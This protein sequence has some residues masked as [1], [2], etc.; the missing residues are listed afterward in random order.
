MTNGFKTKFK[1]SL[2]RELIRQNGGKITYF[3][4][5]GIV[6]IFIGVVYIVVSIL[7]NKAHFLSA[8]KIAVTFFVIM[9]GVAFAFP[10]LLKG[11]TK[12]LSTMRIIVFMFANVICMLLLNIGWNESSLENIGLN[13]YWMGVIAFLFGAKTAQKYF[14]NFRPNPDKTGETV[15]SSKVESELS[16]IAIAQIA[17]VQNE[18]RLLAQFPNIESISETVSLGESCLTLYLNDEKKAG[19]PLSVD[20]KLN[21]NKIVKV[22]TEI[23]TNVGK[24]TI[25]YGQLNHNISDSYSKTYLGSICCAVRSLNYPNFRGIITSGH[26]FT[27]GEYEDYGGYIKTDQIREAYSNDHVIGKLFYQ[28]MNS[29]QD[30]AIVELIDEAVITNEFMTF[31][32]DFYECSIEDL[33]STQPNVTILSKDNKE[34]KAFILDYNYTRQI[35]YRATPK[36]VTNLVVIGSAPKKQDSKSLTKGG[37]SGSCVFHN[38]TKRLIGMLVGGDDKFSFVLP[39][40]ETLRANNLKIL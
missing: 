30:L 16:Q 24:A 9:L 4:I 19:I 28:E 15:P 29:S 17:K 21:D 5:T 37:D 12:E 27:H 31:P 18:A 40:D 22:K 25:Q 23:V 1:N 26:I 10:D 35:Y 3:Q 2:Q 14:E 11:Q 34:Q 20:V 36:Y 39:F 8:E 7:S 6:L 13:G 33:E 38:G 32:T